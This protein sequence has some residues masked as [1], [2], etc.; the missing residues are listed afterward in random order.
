MRIRLQIPETVLYEHP[1]SVRATDMNYG[2]H[3][4][5][6][7]LLVYAQ[8]ARAAWLANLQCHELSIF[9]TQIIL[10]DAAIQ[11]QNEAFLGD[12][13]SVSLHLGKPNRY[14]F[15]LYYRVLK[16]D[17][18]IAEMKTAVLFRDNETHELCSPPAEFLE[19]MHK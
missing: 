10:A 9:G 15:D 7:R 5:N 12:Q 18:S 17:V 14:G 6:D 16:G 13:L 2:G 1:I 3:L 4:G 11:F 19:A 8:E